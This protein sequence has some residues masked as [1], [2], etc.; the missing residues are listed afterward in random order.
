MPAPGLMELLGRLEKRIVDARKERSQLDSQVKAKAEEV[1][2]LEAARQELIRQ[3]RR[4]SNAA[5]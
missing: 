3:R 5:S 1:R 4:R 2:K